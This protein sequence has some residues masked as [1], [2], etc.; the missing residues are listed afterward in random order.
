MKFARALVTHTGNV[1]NAE[2]DEVRKAGYSD[3]DIV[4]IITHVGMNLLTNIS[5]K[6]AMSTSTSRRSNWHW[7]PEFSLNAEGGNPSA[8]EKKEISMSSA[9][10]AIT[11]TPNVKAQQSQM[12]SRSAYAAHE[13]SAGR[14]G[15]GPAEAGFIAARDS[16]YLGTVGESD[17]P[18]AASRRTRR[19]SQSARRAH[20]R[21]C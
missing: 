8:T 18:M 10:S 17:G 21:F 6:P 3:A 15:F 11:F 19:V 16:F 20:D 12:G 1:T 2:L 9:F 13:Q 14:G 4:E 7:P 5:E